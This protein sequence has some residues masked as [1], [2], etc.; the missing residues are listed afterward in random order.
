MALFCADF[1]S[2]Q[3]RLAGATLRPNLFALLASTSDFSYVQRHNPTSHELVTYCRK[4]RAPHVLRQFRSARELPDRLR[5]I[6]I[7]PGVARQISAN[8]G[9]NVPR[10]EI[11]ESSEGSIRRLGKLQNR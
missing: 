3:A 11:V 4:S 2:S 7:S 10:I 6:S 1:R 9:K 8:H 5:Q